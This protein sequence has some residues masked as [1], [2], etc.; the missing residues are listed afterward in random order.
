MGSFIPSITTSPVAASP[1]AAS[2]V[3]ASPVANPTIAALFLL[4]LTSFLVS[5]S[6]L[7][8]RSFSLKYPKELFGSKEAQARRIILQLSSLSSVEREKGARDL[9]KAGSVIAE[10]ILYYCRCGD[11]RLSGAIAFFLA[12]HAGKRGLQFLNKAFASPK[13]SDDFRAKAILA[14]ARKRYE[15]SLP[16]VRDALWSRAWRLRAAAARGLGSWGDKRVHGDLINRFRTERDN[17][18]LP[19]LS[20]ALYRMNDPLGLSYLISRFRN[21]C[22][23]AMTRSLVKS[24]LL[25]IIAEWP[26][27]KEIESQNAQVQR[28]MCENWIYEW[29]HGV[30]P[31]NPIRAMLNPAHGRTR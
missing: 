13:Y 29:E 11:F 21:P 5:P 30:L 18:V 28:R 10:E 8:A 17:R 23:T 31:K 27:Y 2:P 7:L 3:A 15:E 4:F 12:D 16:R 9:A 6:F 14:L 19:E 25:T 24:V 26:R 20:L 1:V 22:G